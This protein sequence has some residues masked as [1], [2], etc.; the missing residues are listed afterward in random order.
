VRLKPDLRGAID[1]AR[2]YAII[3][4]THHK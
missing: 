4:A 3:A 1:R 2:A